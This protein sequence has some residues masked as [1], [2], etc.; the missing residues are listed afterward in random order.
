[1]NKDGLHI[2]TKRELVTADGKRFHLFQD[3]AFSIFNEETNHLDRIICRIIGMSD[4][5]YKK[6]N[7][8]IIA[9]KIE[10]NRCEDNQCVFYFKDM[11][12]INY[13]SNGYF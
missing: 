2:E 9:D 5:D 4:S 3:I 10:R 1:M 13:V 8:Y 11:Q 12:D 7:G 6:D